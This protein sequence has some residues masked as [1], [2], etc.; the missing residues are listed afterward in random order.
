MPKKETTVR[1]RMKAAQH[2]R[3]S[4]A[5]LSSFRM[6]LMQI[7]KAW[8]NWWKK[9]M[10]SKRRRFRASKMPSRPTFLRS[11]LATYRKMMY[12]QST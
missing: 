2:Q 1:K 3:V 11:Q 4:L 8:R 7:L 12:Q 5:I 9:E 6:L 10:L